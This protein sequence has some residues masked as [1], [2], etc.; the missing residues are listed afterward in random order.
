M[1]QK[2]ISFLSNKKEIVL[3]VRTILYICMRRNNAEIHVLGDKIYNVRMTKQSL[4]TALFWYI[5]V[6]WY[7]FWQ[8]TKSVIRYI[9]VQAKNWIM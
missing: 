6:C 5:E 9:L 2:M 8:F 4:E 1:Y 7:Q 3:D